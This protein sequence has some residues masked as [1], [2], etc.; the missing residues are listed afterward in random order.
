MRGTKAL[1]NRADVIDSRDVIDRIDYLQNERKSLKD[2][3]DEAAAELLKYRTTTKLSAE[4]DDELTALDNAKD[5]AEKAVQEWDESEDGE[6]LT[7]L[8]ALQEE[9]EGYCS[10]WKYGAALIRDSY[11]EDYARELAEDC[12][13]L[14]DANEWPLRCIDWEQ[15]ADELKQDYTSVDFDGVTYWVR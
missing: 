2:T 14:K 9:A 7:A 11:F 10:D 5:E 15:A 4:D 3:Y 12:G 13:S 1:D 8:I 6:E